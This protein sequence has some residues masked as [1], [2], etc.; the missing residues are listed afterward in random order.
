MIRMCL[1]N[2]RRIF[3]SGFLLALIL[4]TWSSLNHSETLISTDESN[5]AKASAGKQTVLIMGDSLSAAFG[6]DKQKGWVALLQQSF[7]DQL[8]VVNAS[9]SGETTSG[10]RFRISKALEDH[11]PDLVV[12]EL[13]GNDGLRGTPVAQIKANLDAM[14]QSS[15]S[16]GADVLLLGMRIPPNYGERYTSQFESMFHELAEQ[17]QTLFVPFFLEGAVGLE[18]MIQNDG[19]HPTEKAQPIM[20]NWV[21][22][23]IQQWLSRNEVAL[24]P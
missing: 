18:G 22:P 12:I 24:M 15:R 16:A 3:R 8:K 6:I 17:H 23:V 14:I 20:V 10:G 4:L 13:G 9:I 2:V 11:Q 5:L 1:E 21:E 7:T 19:I